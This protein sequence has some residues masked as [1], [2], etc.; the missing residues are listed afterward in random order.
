MGKDCILVTEIF[1]DKIVI[2]DRPFDINLK[3]KTFI[4]IIIK[5]L[6]IN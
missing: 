3:L 4:V 5:I 2:T 1:E 6:L